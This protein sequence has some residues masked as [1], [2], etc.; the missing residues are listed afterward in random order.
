MEPE[1]GC[2]GGWVS[3][4]VGVY[5]TVSSA[6]MITAPAGHV[7][8]GERERLERSQRSQSRSFSRITAHRPRWPGA[9]CRPHAAV[10]WQCLISS[11]CMLIPRPSTSTASGRWP[12][13]LGAARQGPVASGCMATSSSVPVGTCHLRA[14][15]HSSTALARWWR[16]V[17][18]FYIYITHRIVNLFFPVLCHHLF[19]P[20]SV[21]SSMPHHC[22]GVVTR[23]LRARA[24]PRSHIPCAAEPYARWSYAWCDVSLRCNPSPCQ[25]L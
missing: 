8:E 17:L 18:G 16:C 12:P 7:R 2:M 1:R 23:E 19:L 14:L 13:R 3:G 6:T 21:L 25:L 11:L 5:E 15:R 10:P 4:W 24:G 20:R 22:A 9:Q